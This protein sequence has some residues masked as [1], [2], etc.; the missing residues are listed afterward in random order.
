MKIF[1]AIVGLLLLPVMAMATDVTLAWDYSDD[2]QVDGFRAFAKISTAQFD[3]KAPVA[4]VGPKDRQVKISVAPVEDQLTT[5]QFV[6]RA[7]RGDRESED[8]NICDFIID[9]SPLPA[10]SN[11]KCFLEISE[12]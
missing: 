7:Y 4:Q 6:L 2:V 12:Q 5:Y 1:C 9:L 8:S 3:Y 11:P 10:P